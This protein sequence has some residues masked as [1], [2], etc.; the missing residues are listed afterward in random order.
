MDLS[1]VLD[2]DQPPPKPPK[3]ALWKSATIAVLSLAAIATVVW[4][5][6]AGPAKG[7]KSFQRPQ[8]PASAR[9]FID[10]GRPLNDPAIATLLRGP[11]TKFVVQLDHEVET[12]PRPAPW[13]T[14]GLAA[15]RDALVAA[16]S[17]KSHGVDL[18]NAWTAF[19][20]AFAD[21]RELPESVAMAAHLIEVSR[22]LSAAFAQAGLG[23]YVDID[24][25]GSGNR[26][27]VLSYTYDIERVSF[28]YSGEKDCI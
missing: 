3:M 18:A 8:S 15:A 17:M 26:L 24:V 11:F 2:L 10:G 12:E 20:T 21:W 7:R 23:Y 22:K 16:P 6:A 14:P 4:L 5:I 1:A 13:A 28:V 27:R 25:L 19:M 9:A